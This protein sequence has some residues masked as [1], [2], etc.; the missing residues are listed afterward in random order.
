MSGVGSGRMSLVKTVLPQSGAGGAGMGQ[1]WASPWPPCW[2]GSS[3][4][5]RRPAAVGRH[6]KVPARWNIVAVTIGHPKV[7]PGPAG[8]AASGVSGSAAGPGCRP[9]SGLAAPSLPR[10]W[11][12]CCACTAECGRTCACS[13][14]DP[15]PGDLGEVDLLAPAFAGEDGQG[16]DRGSSQQRRG[17]HERETE[18]SAE[19]VTGRV[20]RPPRG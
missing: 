18:T 15:S 8:D 1:P 6:P 10:R 11:A 13:A 17:D 19:R 4:T 14:L 9:R 7:L 16:E 3:G 5:V 12:G 20:P 2:P